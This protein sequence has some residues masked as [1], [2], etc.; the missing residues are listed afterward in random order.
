[1]TLPASPPRYAV[2]GNPIAHSRSP[3]IHAMFSAQTGR[4]LRYERLL[5]PVDGFLPT[6][7][8]F[9]ESGG[10]GLN[11]TVPFK[12]EAYALAEARLSER[13]RL[14]GAVN[15]LSW[16]DGAWHGC[17]TDGVGLVNDLLRLGV[18]LAGARVLLV[19]AGGAARGVLQPLAAAGC[20]RIH[21][22][23]RTA[24]RA[25]ELA[26]AWRAAAPRTGT[27]VSA[28]ALA[29]A[30]E[31]G[32]WDVAINAT[33]SSLQD[34]APDLPGGLYAPDAL[35]YDMMYGARPTAFMRQAEADGAARCADGLGMLVGQAAESFHIWHG[36]RP[37]P[38][39]VLLALRTELLAAG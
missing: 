21:I 37:D 34:A 20:A 36:V 33:A 7:Q 35:A 23:N 12:L 29:Q 22:V 10:L 25:A 3:Q 4:P 17:N 24:A 26:A 2:I 15:T 18:A 38:G 14:A 9:R 32:G 30:A 31:P 16:R 8:A 13:A 1:M 27:Q 6:V 5:A 11:V 28:G 19:G 39:P